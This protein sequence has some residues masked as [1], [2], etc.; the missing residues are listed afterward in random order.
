MQV[1][2]KNTQ[3]TIL[4]IFK[5]MVGSVAL[6]TF[7]LLW[8]G[9][10][11]CDVLLMEGVIVLLLNVYKSGTFHIKMQMSGIWQRKGNMAS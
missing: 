7:T 1:Q 9:S 11:L 3:F 8:R 2:S 5:C 6:T 10:T 4:T